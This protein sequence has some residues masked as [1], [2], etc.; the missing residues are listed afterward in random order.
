MSALD[1]VT[2]ER[3]RELAERELEKAVYHRDRPSFLDRMLDQIREWLDGLM[4]DPP[5]PG[6]GQGSGGLTIV[7]LLV[8]FAVV[9]AA[10]LWW[11]RGRRNPS[12]S[13]ALLDDEPTRA[14]DH[15][16]SAEALAAEGRYAEAIR[17]RLRAIARD[18]E[19][20]AILQ[21][22]PGRTALELAL[23]ASSLLPV[24]LMPGARVFDDVWYGDRPGT[25]EGYA[26]LVDLD[27][28]VRAAKPRPLEAV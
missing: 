4:P 8:L 21:A 6:P 12:G 24:D 27:A 26:L 11:M 13:K 15:R 14:A 23:E 28:S 7:V 3:A 22:R 19:E 16:T 5:A 9:V 17:E 20:R 2:R 10:V 1:P 18:L 25:P